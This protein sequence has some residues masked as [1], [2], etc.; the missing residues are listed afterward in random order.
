MPSRMHDD[1]EALIGGCARD[2][3]DVEYNYRRM[4]SDDFTSSALIRFHERSRED[5]RVMAE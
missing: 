5:V 4:R 2:Q 1:V 3:I